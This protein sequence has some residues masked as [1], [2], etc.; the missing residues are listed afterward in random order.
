MQI[1]ILGA[2]GLVGQ[3]VFSLLTKS[4]KVWGTSRDTK[5]PFLFQFNCRSA[6]KDVAKIFKKIGHIDYVINCIGVYKNTVLQDLIYINS[7]FPHVLENLAA[8]YKFRLFHIS[9]D[10][11]F[12]KMAGVVDE[13]VQPIPDTI[14]GM[15]KLLGETTTNAALTI[16]TSFLGFDRFHHAGFLETDTSEG[17]INQQWSGCT[18][19]QFARFCDLVIK[20][21][22][23]QKLRKTSSFYH[24]TPIEHTTKYAILA[25]YNHLVFP[26]K[27]IK[28]TKG[29][30]RNRL[31]HTT[32]LSSYIQPQ[33]LEKALQE[34]ISYNQTHQVAS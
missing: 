15:T 19:L 26:L 3:T 32:L 5:S 24:F 33:S 30:Q 8:E 21:D 23:F 4:Y 1:L 22:I 20:N 2:T 27:G 34:A 25:T 11:V 7:Y 14:Y 29:E 16:R 6:E 31:L 10:A 28:K 13:T 17:Y 9:S 18:T 12:G